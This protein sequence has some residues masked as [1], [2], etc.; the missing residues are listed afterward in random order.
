M[1]TTYDKEKKEEEKSHPIS[2]LSIFP[3]IL[4]FFLCFPRHWAMVFI[5]LLSFGNELLF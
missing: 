5:M 2:P 4:L 3:I 1:I